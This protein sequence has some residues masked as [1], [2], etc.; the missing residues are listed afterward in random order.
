MW[1]SFYNL[2]DESVFGNILKYYLE[3]INNGSIVDEKSDS[4]S[5]KESL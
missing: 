5:D 2:F 4:I 3:C 1:S